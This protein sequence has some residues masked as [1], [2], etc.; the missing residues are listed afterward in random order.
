MSP[1]AARAADWQPKDSLFLPL[2]LRQDN[3]STG[4]PETG[5]GRDG[6]GSCLLSRVS[7]YDQHP[8]RLSKVSP[9]QQLKMSQ[10]IKVTVIKANLRLLR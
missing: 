7:H 10:R 2:G 4:S 9:F 3:T 8:L 6:L 1:C 5:W